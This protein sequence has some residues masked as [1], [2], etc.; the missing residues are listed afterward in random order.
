MEYIVEK[1][2]EWF[3]CDNV[4]ISKQK[5]MVSPQKTRAIVELAKG[6]SNVVYL[7]KLNEKEEL[8]KISTCDEV[9]ETNWSISGEPG[10]FIRLKRVAGEEECIIS[11]KDFLTIGHERTFDFIDNGVRVSDEHNIAYRYFKDNNSTIVWNGFSEEIHKIGGKVLLFIGYEDGLC[12]I[13]NKKHPGFGTLYSLVKK[14]SIGSLDLKIQYFG[15]INKICFCQYINEKGEYEN[16]LISLK[17]DTYEISVF[18]KIE[19]MFVGKVKIPSESEFYEN[20]L[21]N[22]VNSI[23][24]VRKNGKFNIMISG[25]LISNV[26]FDSY[27]S[28]DEF[29]NKRSFHDDSKIPYIIKCYEQEDKLFYDILDISVNNFEK[30]CYKWRYSHFGN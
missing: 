6:D 18:D 3:G 24:V 1:I 4:Y 16:N 20:I 27:E 11:K 30:C 8:I 15:L 13:A 10:K 25:R 26:W 29:G 21:K 28:F 14:T 7:F 17:T 9:S 12:L 2:F 5:I 23:I 19:H 22:D